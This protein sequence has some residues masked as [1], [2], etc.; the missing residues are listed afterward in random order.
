MKRQ[1]ITTIWLIMLLLGLASCKSSE[2][3]QGDKTSV[4]QLQQVKLNGRNYWLA[5]P[6]GYQAANSYKLLLAFHPSGGNGKD[7]QSFTH[8][9][10]ISNE[11]IVA[12][13]DSEQVEWNEGC[14]CNIAHRL[15]ADDLGFTSRIITDIQ[16]RHNVIPDEVYAAGYSQGGLFV[17]NLACNLP[18][19]FKAVAVV[20]APMSIQL[21]SSCSPSTAVS[22]MM[23]HGTDDTVLPYN[24]MVHHNF[25]L[26]SSADAIALIAGKNDALP[27]ALHKTQVAPHTH[28][29]SYHNGTQKF[30]LYSVQGGGHTWQFAGFD[31]SRQILNFFAEVEQ[32]E[33]PEHS[34]L[35]STEQG[36]FHVRAMGMDNPGPAVVLLAGPNYNY[37]SDSAWFAALQP[38][39]AKQY[40][41]Y[42]I[43][44]LGNAY[45]SNT[46]ELS[47][48]RFADDLAAVLQQLQEI[49]LALV[50]FSSSSIS[51]RWFYQ[52]HQQQFDIKAM[53]YIDPDI[54][55]PHSLS[56]YQGYPADW[57]LANLPALLPHLAGGNWTGRTK[58]KLDVE[59]QEVQQLVAQH[60]V[61]LD[62]SYF[63][64][65]M[66]LRLLIPQQ[67]ARAREIAAYIAD[68]DGYAQLPMVSA[69]PVS[70]I[71]SDFEQQQIDLAQDEPELAAA[72]RLWQQEGS[73]WS[74]EQALISNGQY[75][76]LS[77]SDHLVPVQ[78]PEQIK[79]ALDWLFRALQLP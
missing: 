20:A 5:L 7:M 61:Q 3:N 68:L 8:F 29:T 13:P 11:Y 14:N 1:T 23:V 52:Q 41:V 15:G 9:D 59:Y 36:Q 73:A 44:R 63:E 24:G 56:L 28:L 49:Q 77:N 34:Q 76:A 16:S 6:R 19:L 71:D 33:L 74:A 57:Y 58:D 35:V 30:Q 31:T 2:K 38:L 42:S 26:I 64:Q 51:A 70:V 4:A 27:Y 75:I 22:L 66:Q 32:P 12:Y 21:A 69:I 54:P 10:Q 39:L 18:Q 62:W 50:A 25:G 40:R 53:V 79:Q 48:R 46:E 60:N 37:H 78:K 67:Q 65:I 45:S 55:L 43:D 47:Y 72:L 17:Q